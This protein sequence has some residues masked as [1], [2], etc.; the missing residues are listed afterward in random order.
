MSEPSER[1]SK[2]VSFSLRSSETPIPSSPQ[3]AA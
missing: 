2:T 3:A 1:I